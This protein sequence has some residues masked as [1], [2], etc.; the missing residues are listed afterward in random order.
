M[1]VEDGVDSD[2]PGSV[3]SILCGLGHLLRK[4]STPFATELQDVKGQVR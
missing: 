2:E 3:G 1:F 4:D